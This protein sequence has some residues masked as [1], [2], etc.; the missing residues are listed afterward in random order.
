MRRRVT[1]SSIPPWLRRMGRIAL[2]RDAR[3]D[4]LHEWRRARRGEPGIPPGP[5]R[6]VLVVCHGNICRSPFAG[7]LLARR[8][9][10]VRSAGLA[11]RDGAP[12]EPDAVRAARRFAVN[13]AAH[14]ARRLEGEDV[15]WAELILAM[16]GHQLA[17]MRREHPVAAGRAHLLGDFLPAPPYAIADPW[18]RSESV[19]AASFERIAE[20]VERLAARLDARGG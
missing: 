15:G 6:N 4:A 3:Q 7:A 1:R 16:E 18:G 13:L 9:L 8:G 5:I 20:A 10:A 17:R 11:A 2:S 14:R 19:F 12:A